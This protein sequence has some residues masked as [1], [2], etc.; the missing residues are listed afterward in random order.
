MSKTPPKTGKGPGKKDRGPLLNAH[1]DALRTGLGVRDEVFKFGQIHQLLQILLERGDVEERHAAVGCLAVLAQSDKHIADVVTNKVLLTA[2]ALLL[3][4]HARG[5][6][7]AVQLLK[8][9]AGRQELAGKVADTSLPALVEVLKT[10]GLPGWGQ[11]RQAQTQAALTIKALLENVE[12][13]PPEIRQMRRVAVLQLGAVPPLAAMVASAPRLPPPSLLPAPPPVIARRKAGASRKQAARTETPL[14]SRDAAATVAS[15]CLR[16]LALVP[17]FVDEF[18]RTGALPA[19]ISGLQTCGEEQAAYLCGVLWEATAEARVAEAAVAAGGVVSLLHVASRHLAGCRFGKP[20]AASAATKPGDK[21]KG[22]SRSSSPSKA[23]GKDGKGGKGSK[24]KAGGGSSGEAPNFAD[25]A[26][27]N[28]T[29]ALQ[30]LTFLD[31]A[32]Q[33]V[34]MHGGV[35]ILTAC[36]KVSNSQTY[37]N[38]AGALW[39]VGLDVRN[40]VVLQASGAPGFLARPVPEP[41]L[42]RPGDPTPEEGPPRD[43]SP[44]RASPTRSP[45]RD[46]DARDRVFLTQQVL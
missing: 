36:L 41:W 42:T 8:L 23:E 14:G 34:A 4:E 20:K 10:D 22:S 31:A 16:F 43:P 38:A 29:G 3:C 25:I 45:G 37:E 11:M 18:M 40:G 44:D 32:K 27:C 30:H 13:E 24:G 46:R 39:N 6:L 7:P 2:S 28:A 1:A 15:A 12:G 9:C 35:P 21:K 33:Q 19:V 26:V 5:K 17:E